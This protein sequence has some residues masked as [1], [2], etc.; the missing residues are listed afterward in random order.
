MDSIK[1]IR[2]IPAYSGKATATI[3]TSKNWW[4]RLHTQSDYILH[5]KHIFSFRTSQ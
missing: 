3:R 2:N 4:A 5:K 1:L